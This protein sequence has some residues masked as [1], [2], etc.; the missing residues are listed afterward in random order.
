MLRHHG[1]GHREEEDAAS[2]VESPPGPVAVSAD[3]AAEVSERASTGERSWLRV[4]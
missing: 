3:D 2:A 4:L 1:G